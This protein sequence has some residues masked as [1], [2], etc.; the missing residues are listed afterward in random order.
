MLSPA[1]PGTPVTFVVG[2]ARRDLALV[3]ADVRVAHATID[4]D[5]RDIT[6]SGY[7]DTGRKLWPLKMGW[8]GVGG[9]DQW[10]QAIYRDICGEVGDIRRLVRQA[11]QR[12]AL[13]L[14]TPWTK[15]FTR[16]WCV[17]AEDDGLKA[18][19]LNWEGR[20]AVQV[21]PGCAVSITTPREFS[22][23]EMSHLMGAY[24][25]LIRTCQDR[26][27]AAIATAELWQ[28]IIARVGT[29]GAYSPVL[30]LGW[31]FRENGTIRRAHDPPVHYTTILES[32]P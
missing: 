4:P 13:E 26:Q 22:A 18:H 10:V 25:R 5:G 6:R 3:A 32:R 28:A 29:D 20:P 17:C 2:W 8:V 9:H 30:E 14:A 31:L 27:S 23:T 19:F 15:K 21:R 24:G 11:A 1:V 7:S 16:F 12:R